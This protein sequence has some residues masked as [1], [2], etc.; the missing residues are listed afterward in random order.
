MAADLVY[1]KALCAEKYNPERKDESICALAESII[2]S[3]FNIVTKEDDWNH[4][5]KLH[6]WQHGF[7]QIGISSFTFNETLRSEYVE[8]TQWQ[9]CIHLP[10]T[11]DMNLEEDQI[12]FIEKLM[13][14][15][16]QMARTVNGQVFSTVMSNIHE[17]KYI[18]DIEYIMQMFKTH[19]PLCALRGPD[20]KYELN[21]KTILLDSLQDKNSIYVVMVSRE[22]SSERVHV[23]LSEPNARIKEEYVPSEETA[24]SRVPPLCEFDGIRTRAQ[25]KMEHEQY[26]AAVQT[27]L[28][29]CTKHIHLILRHS[30]ACFVPEEVKVIRLDIVN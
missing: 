2:F 23:D 28:A 6:M 30:F 5:G 12:W 13:D 22:Q 10:L 18:Q 21:M 26:Q 20:I 14:Y 24:R 29:K 27:E 25:R 3:V 15:A 1:F 16:M 4:V 8:A 19:H 9:M 11:F 17:T 7:N